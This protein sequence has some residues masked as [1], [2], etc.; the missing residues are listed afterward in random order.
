MDEHLT[1]EQIKILLE[2][3]SLP[4]FK[5]LFALNLL[6]KQ[7]DYILCIDAETKILK[8]PDLKRVYE[9]KVVIGGIC[10][11]PSL[12]TIIKGTLKMFKDISE[13]KL[14]EI[15]DNYNY[16][17]WW[18][19]MPVY[20]TNNIPDFLEKIGFDDLN[21]FIERIEYNFFENMAYN[22]YCLLYQGFTKIVV[23]N[24]NHSLEGQITSIVEKYINYNIG[25]ISLN[26][27]NQNKDFYD[28]K[29]NVYMIYH[30][31]RD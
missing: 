3:K 21:S 16:Y 26:T 30:L 28:K 8:Q 10:N 19:S 11:N 17:T 18:S 25:W 15:S 14:S 9:K 27:Y 6:N 22:Y 31:D 4:S 7:Y 29:D 24:I 5:K 23:P 12:I 1:S 20:K 13:T 2:K